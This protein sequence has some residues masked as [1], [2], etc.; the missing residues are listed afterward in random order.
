MVCTC[1]VG[2]CFDMNPIQSENGIV[3]LILKVVCFMSAMAHVCPPLF[4]MNMV[5]VELASLK[6]IHV[7]AALIHGLRRIV[8]LD[9][10]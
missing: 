10:L 2:L 8:I 6:C 5:S 3:V 1:A 7:F 9:C 4:L